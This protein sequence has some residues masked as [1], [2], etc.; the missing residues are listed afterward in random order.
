M[1][2]YNFSRGTCV[3]IHDYCGGRWM[4]KSVHIGHQQ[5]SKE[6]EEHNVE[7]Q[8]C[9]QVGM[10]LQLCILCCGQLIPPEHQVLEL[11]HCKD[12]QGADAPPK[13]WEAALELLCG[14]WKLLFWCLNYRRLCTCYNC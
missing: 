14:T 3:I 1:E 9:V 11:G 12:D 2:V 13:V 6:A 5:R 4:D 8:G 10:Y 7:Q